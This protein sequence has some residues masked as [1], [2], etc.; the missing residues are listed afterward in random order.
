MVP[1]QGTNE[2]MELNAELKEELT[3]VMVLDDDG[4]WVEVLSDEDGN[5]YPIE[6]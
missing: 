3:P 6:A 2:L 4:K 1:E 5:L